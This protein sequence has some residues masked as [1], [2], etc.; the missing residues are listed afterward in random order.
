MSEKIFLPTSEKMK[1]TV[2]TETDKARYRIIYGIHHI[3]TDPATLENLDGVMLEIINPLESEEGVRL[4]VEHLQKKVLQYRKLL[5]HCQRH[6]IPIFLTDL[7][8]NAYRQTEYHNEMAIKEIYLP[9]LE[10]I[11]GVIL[12]VSGATNVVQQKG[13]SRREFLKQG[14][15][16]LV[17]SYLLMSQVNKSLMETKKEPDE[18]A[19][20]RQFSKQ[21]EGITKTLHPE[22]RNVIV[23]GRNDLF[24]QKGEVIADTIQ[25]PNNRKPNLG[26]VIGAAHTGIED[27]LHLT[28]Q[29]RIE[30]LKKV[31]G[32]KRLAVERHIVRLDFPDPNSDKLKISRFEDKSLDLRDH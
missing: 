6:G 32:E 14:L 8:Y 18:K 11:L 3:E 23:A 10:A 9:V 19:K 22:M 21:L 12:V 7:S 15:K 20:M 31:F 28:E 26:I 17:G 24:A 27:S 4:S 29:E 16:G 1:N 13:I 5:Q 30:R 25:T 2:E